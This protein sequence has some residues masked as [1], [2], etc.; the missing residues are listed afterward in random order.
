MKDVLFLLNSLPT[1][2]GEMKARLA[3][4]Q[5]VAGAE[6][7]LALRSAALAQKGGPTYPEGEDAEVFIG[8]DLRMLRAIAAEPERHSPRP[9]G[10]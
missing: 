5:V 8:V 9:T 6:F 4:G 1:G 2:F 10:A 3:N 7:A